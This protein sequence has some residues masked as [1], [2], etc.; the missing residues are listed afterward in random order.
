MG[1]VRLERYERPTIVRR[2]RI[3]ALL[4]DTSKSEVKPDGTPSDVNVKA[5]IQPVV[6]GGETV[7]Y[8]EPAIADRTALAGFLTVSKSDPKQDGISDVNVKAN[9]RP[10]EWPGETVVYTQPAIAD[11]TPISGFL[12]VAKSNPKQDV[13]QPSDVRIKDNIVPVRW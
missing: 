5:N 7:V 2:D 11:R 6:W 13:T 8:T 10:V 12:I 4:I 3:E 9:L 1:N